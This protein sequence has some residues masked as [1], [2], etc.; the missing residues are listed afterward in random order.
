[1]NGRSQLNPRRRVFDIAPVPAQLS[2]TGARKLLGLFVGHVGGDPVRAAVGAHV[3][4]GVN[5]DVS[6]RPT[7]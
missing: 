3:V 2:D 4:F 5:S 1:M 6:R 7:A